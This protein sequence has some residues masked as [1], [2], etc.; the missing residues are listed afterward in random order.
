MNTRQGIRAGN[1]IWL[2]PMGFTLGGGLNTSDPTDIVCARRAAHNVLYT[3]VDTI[4]YN[5]TFDHDSLDTIFNA[6]VGVAD[7]AESFAWWIILLVV[8]DVAAVAGL[9]VWT[10][11]LVKPKK[12]KVR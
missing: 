6:N 11:F 5:H 3:L 2:N 4:Y 1:D 8:I 7:R 12:E 10:V 9:V